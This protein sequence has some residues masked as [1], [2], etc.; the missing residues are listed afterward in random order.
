MASGLTDKLMDW[1]D[2]VRLIDER[3]AAENS[4]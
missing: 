1:T 3:E 2:I 4:K